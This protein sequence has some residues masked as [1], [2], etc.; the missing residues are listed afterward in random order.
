[1]KRSKKRKITRASAKQKGAGL[2]NFV[3]KEL[4]ELTGLPA[5]TGD[6]CL[7]KPRPGGHKGVDI[8]ITGKASEVLP[9]SIECK[10]QESWHLLGAI[11]QAKENQK[12]D[13]DWVVILKKARVKPVVVIDWE[14]FKSLL[15]NVITRD[16]MIN[17]INE[18]LWMK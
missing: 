14:F 10:N 3:V 7:I 6:D 9:L 18:Y 17:N 4:G 15:D 12:F 16:K 1:M 2:Q 11:K 8:I 13:T 5:G